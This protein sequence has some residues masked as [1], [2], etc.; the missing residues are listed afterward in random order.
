EFRKSRR[1]FRPK[2]FIFRVRTLPEFNAS[3]CN[4]FTCPP[5]QVQDMNGWELIGT[6]GVTLKTLGWQTIDLTA[7]IR[8]WTLEARP[9]PEA[10]VTGGSGDP[11]I[12]DDKLTL[13]VDCAG[14]HGLIETGMPPVDF[15]TTDERSTKVWLKR[16]NFARDTN[17]A[18]FTPYF[19]IASKRSAKSRRKRKA[20]AT[21]PDDDDDGGSDDTDVARRNCCV[22][23]LFVSFKDL[24]WDEWILYPDGYFANYCF[25]ECREPNFAHF[26]THVL[27]DYRNLFQGTDEEY[28]E[29]LS[30]CCSPTKLSSIS[31]IYYDQK[32]RIIKRDLPK[33]R[34][35]ECGCA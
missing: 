28:Y 33:M 4:S 35:D 15:D 1:D 27:K 30:P 9:V 8:N 22:R 6:L 14:C 20:S 29:A 12:I 23:R 34:V 5:V 32:K 10:N 2:V 18:A 19:V 16:R 31:L 7:A 25:G 13:L 26:N 21:C 11:L 17:S 3:A 24:G